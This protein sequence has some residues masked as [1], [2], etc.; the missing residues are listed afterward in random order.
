MENQIES[1]VVELNNLLRYKLAVVLPT[2]LIIL[3]VVV[4]SIIAIL[5]EELASA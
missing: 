3:L 2:L 1:A 5:T 4:G